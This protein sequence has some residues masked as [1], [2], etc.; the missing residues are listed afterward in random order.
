MAKSAS[1]GAPLVACTQVLRAKIE[2][3]LCQTTLRRPQKQL[4]QPCETADNT[5]LPPWR[6][7]QRPR[8][9]QRRRA[10]RPK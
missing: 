5:P 9:Q 7:R 1:R 4:A 2:P 6:P 8:L 3:G 10:R